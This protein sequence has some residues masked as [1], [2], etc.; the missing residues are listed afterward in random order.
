VI[1]V[2]QTPHQRNLTGA[3]L[4]CGKRAK[5]IPP[6][7]FDLSFPDSASSLAPRSFPCTLERDASRLTDPMMPTRPGFRIF[8]IAGI[9]IYVHPTWLVIFGLI[10]WTL[11]EQYSTQHPEWSAQQHWLVGILTS[12][13]FFG[14]VIFHEMAHSLVAQHYKIKVISI[15]LF[16]F[17]GVARIERDPNKAIQ[18]FNIAVAG[19]LASLFLYGAFIAVAKIFPYSHVTGALA[20]WLAYINLRLALFNMLPGFPL[21]GG[22]I[23]RAIA[24]GVTGNY[25]KATRLAGLSGKLVAY[26]IILFGAWIAL[27][28]N[29]T[30]G[31]WIK[32][33]G[34]FVTGLWT[35][36]IGWFILNA[37]QESVAQVEVRETL[38]GLRAQ[39]VMSH[40]VPTFP[41]GDTL[42]D[43][44]AEV[45]RTG[46]R[47][48]LVLTDDRLT[49]MM[50]VHVL[51]AVPREEWAH[52]SVQG[53][54]T[55]RDSI[56][57]AQPDEP[58]LGLLERL[59][60]NEVNQMPVV[61]K[62]DGEGNMQIIGM[63]TRDSILRVIQ[64]R[65]ELGGDSF[66]RK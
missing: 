48:H 6:A 42:E 35:A 34:D 3:S 10:T 27:A 20:F 64:T 13:L 61:T 16:I 41:G 11:V 59:L 47:F 24:W 63:V 7:T 38:I 39:D 18:E 60:A 54:M 36:F 21:D 58:L 23:F 55:P 9:P 62:G 66:P 29:I 22:R 8:T 1:M 44:A 65:S 53:V 57:L 43:Y 33:E 14:S 15:T 30:I 5:A 17:G 40:E 25:S 51:N 49:G 32:I 2:N 45:L 19:P 52:T 50:N 56:L 37:A 46:R 26:A 31:P 12:L 4:S 28:K